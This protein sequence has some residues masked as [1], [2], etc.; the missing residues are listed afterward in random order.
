MYAMDK[1]MSHRPGGTELNDKIFHHI[2]Y[3][4]E[5]SKTYKWFISGIFNLIISEQR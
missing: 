3:N 4:S 2:T 5:Q 1:G